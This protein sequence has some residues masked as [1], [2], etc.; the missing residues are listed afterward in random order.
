MHFNIKH[1]IKR[2]KD[3]TFYNHNKTFAQLA[4]VKIMEAFLLY[5][6]CIMPSSKMELPFISGFF[7]ALMCIAPLLSHYFA[8][9][10]VTKTISFLHIVLSL[11]VKFIRNSNKIKEQKR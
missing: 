8:A 2:K 4:C 1:K 5:S 10:A 9:R 11:S 7:V 3:E 6:K